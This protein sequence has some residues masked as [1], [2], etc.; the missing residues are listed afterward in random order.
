MTEER[1]AAEVQV[2][3]SKAKATGND[4]P[5]GIVSRRAT[6][7]DGL[8]VSFDNRRSQI[9]AYAATIKYCRK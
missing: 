8:L 6:D 5:A 1:K 4:A 2:N 3:A 9:L 7:T